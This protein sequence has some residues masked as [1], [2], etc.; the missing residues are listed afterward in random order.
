MALTKS[1]G[2]MYPWVTHTHTHIGGECPHKCSYCYVQAMERRFNGGKYQGQ[3]K[4]H[5]EEFEVNYGKGRTIFIEHC[6]DMWADKVPDRWI[7]NILN[8][9]QSYP[10]NIYVFQTKNPRR[11][12]NW[13]KHIPANSILGCTIE[14]DNVNTN[15]SVPSPQKRVK[16]MWLLPPLFIKFI[17][18][19]PLLKGNMKTLAEWIIKINPD[20]VNIGADSK[21]AGL[22]EPTSKEVIYLIEKIKK[23]GIEIKQ[24]R[25]LD[26]LL[27]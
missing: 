8:H 21:G 25:N 16:P 18:I 15:G 13:I 22:K 5:E 1:K 27:K 19:E 20:F 24:K 23:A 26:R 10:E 11:Y 7:R 14:S 4:L 3:L 17:T 12:H 2:N 9:C 6:N